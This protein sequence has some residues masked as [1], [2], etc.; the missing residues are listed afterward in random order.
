MRRLAILAAL[1][2]SL[3]LFSAAI[4]PAPVLEKAQA[5]YASGDHAQALAFYDSVATEYSSAA[6]LFNIGNCYSK[7]DDLPHAILYYER[8]LLLAPGAEDIQANL[9]MQRAKVVDR[10]N[11]LPAFTLG[12]AWDSTIGGKDVDQWARR[13]LWACFLMVLAA[14][15][16]ILVR[17]PAIRR[18]LL[19]LAVL[20]LVF[21]VVSTALAAY[22]VKEV[23]QRKEAIIIVPSVDILGEPREGSTRLFILHQG[24]KVGVLG[25]HG[26]WQEVR[27]PNGSVGWLPKAR[28]EKI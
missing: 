11:Q 5:A 24:S 4:D 20:A 8:A 3:T 19:A 28:I 6:L 27:L 25:E 10:I 13:S 22:R 2:S 15:A 23:E 9:D 14:G 12:S 16:A 1:A 7:L 21:T 17:K 26:D 18:S